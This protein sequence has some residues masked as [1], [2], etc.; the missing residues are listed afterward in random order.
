MKSKMR[1]LY[2]IMGNAHENLH[3]NVIV[4]YL[5]LLNQLLAFNVSFTKMLCGS[6]VTKAQT[7]LPD[8]KIRNL[9]IR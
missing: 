9:L 8:P 1:L 7:Q 2:V 6:Y 4:N 3:V 5:V